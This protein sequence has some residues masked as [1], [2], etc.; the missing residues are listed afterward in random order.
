MTNPTVSQGLMKVAN[1]MTP[2]LPK[3]QTNP[4]MMIYD[5]ILSFSLIFTNKQSQN[6]REFLLILALI[7]YLK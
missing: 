4:K 7:N 6:Q 5:I 3:K 1:K 2:N